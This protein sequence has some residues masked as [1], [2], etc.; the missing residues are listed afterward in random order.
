MASVRSI[1]AIFLACVLMISQI[2]FTHVHAAGGASA[3]ETMTMVICTPDGMQGVEMPM[4]AHESSDH[5]PDHSHGAFCPH[6]IVGAAITPPAPSWAGCGAV[7]RA[8]AYVEASIFQPVAS[9]GSP[10]PARAPPVVTL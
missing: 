3:Q 4:G 8:V 5:G 2:V 9:D 6:C 7:I 1:T 10:Y